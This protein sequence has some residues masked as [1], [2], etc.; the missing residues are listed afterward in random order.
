[1]GSASD[2]LGKV[3]WE[4]APRLVGTVYDREMHRAANDR[5]PVRFEAFDAERG[6]WSQVFCYPLP[7]GGLATQWRDITTRKHAEEAA[8]YLA[9]ASEVL[10]SSL[11][12]EATLGALARLVVPDLADWCAV[13]LADDGA[14]LRQVAVAHVQPE[15]VEFAHELQR[16]YPPNPRAPTG[17][18]QVIRT[19]APELL[20]DIPD[21]LLAMA[22]RDEDHLRIMRELGLRSAMIVPLAARGRTMGALTM[23]TAESPR[24]YGEADLEL[25]MEL[26]RRAGMA[27]D[28]ARL[29]AEM[30]R[31]VDRTARLQSV[32][33]GLA[34]TITA[35]DVADTVVAES[36]AAF[37]AVDGV[38]CVPTSDGAALEI[39]HSLGLREE[40]TQQYRTFPI[41]AP[42]PLSEAVRSGQPI[43]LGSKQDLVARYPQLREANR[44][45]LTEAWIALPLM[46][47]E[48]V[49]GGLALGFA[50]A[51]HF[52]PEDHAF[53][54][55]LAQ[56][57]AQALDRAALYSA[58]REARAEAES[59]NMA[60]SDFLATMSHEL[61]TPLNAIAGYAELL[62]M[63]IHGPLSTPQ[64]DAIVR[65]QRSQRH[66]L[67][68]IND[69]LNFARIEAGQLAIN[70]E[71][72]AM[73][74]LV[75]ELEPLIAP[76]LGAKSLALD[77]GTCEEPYIARADPEKVRQ[78]LLNLLSNAIKFTARG[79]RITVSC[80]QTADTVRVHIQDT[81]SGIPADQ[82]E[83]IFEPFV[84]LNRTLA[85]A[86]EGAGL[87]LAISRDLARA[88]S[89]NV[90]VKSTPGSG[91]TFTLELPR[92]T[93]ED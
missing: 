53:A 45:A 76:Q 68:L 60:K 34:R 37:G 47:D 20:A 51:R 1:M 84:Q 18:P 33:A 31:A 64:R 89:G 13:H 70:L 15:K 12:H 24:R 78:I 65:I 52:T 48:R 49:L 58:E 26:G 91:S 86:H 54:L 4:A 3:V 7:D 2:L 75:H 80:E 59:A 30:R 83:Q 92:A 71:N 90:L 63:G 43:M 62:E 69:I 32:T 29:F 82:L 67:A 38:F 19:G 56:Q 27:V 73:R 22:A 57:A 77:L 36:V 74:D 6:E 35:E 28:N 11:D 41:D 93:G 88:M 44:R 23:I 16:R 42:L 10:V 55:A 5:T 39:V 66:L 40:T 17:V 72:V 79:G 25:A 9:R 61:R 87:G 81:G 8:H 46:I 14:E 21:Q 50:E 85:S